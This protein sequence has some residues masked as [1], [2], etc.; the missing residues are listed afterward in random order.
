MIPVVY[1]LYKVLRVV[2]F[3]KTE[4]RMM[5]TRGWWEEGMECYCLM[6]LSLRFFCFLFLLRK[7]LLFP[8]GAQPQWGSWVVESSLV[9]AGEARTEAQTPRECQRVPFR[10]CRAM[11]T[12]SCV[13]GEPFEEILALP[14]GWPACAAES[15][16][17]HPLELLLI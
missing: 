10:G 7:T 6:G 1:H 5:A 11:Q 12:Q 2:K 3:V 8:F 16:G 4:S 9:A 14:S 13:R 15:G 17:H